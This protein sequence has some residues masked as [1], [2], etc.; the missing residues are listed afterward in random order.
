MVRDR[1]RLYPGGSIVA[2]IAAGCAAGFV[3]GTAG[4][5]VDRE[6]AGPLGHRLSTLI[7]SGALFTLLFGAGWTLVAATRLLRRPRH[8]TPGRIQHYTIGVS[9]VV[10]F[11]TLLIAVF[12][13][14]ASRDVTNRSP[15][16]ILIS[17][18]TLR[19]DHLSA[20]G[21]RRET[22][23]NLDALA[24]DGV[25]FERAFAQSP[26]TLPSHASMMTGLGPV[27]HG[28]VDLHSALTDA[29][30]TL[31]ERLG[32]MGYDTGAFVGGTRASFIGAKRRLDQ[33]FG[34][35][36]QYP[37]PRPGWSGLIARRLDHV[38]LKW[39]DH[40]VGNARAEIAASLRWIETR[41]RQPFFLF[42]HL[43]DVH[44]KTVR[45][46][47][48]AP[49]PFRERFCAGVDAAGFD[50]CA[51]GGHCASEYLHDLWSGAA[52]S[53]SPDTIERMK[54][55]YD[56]GIAFVDDE[57][58]R[59]FDRLRHLG[60][61]ENTLVVVTSDHGEAFFE[62][63]VPDHT[64]LYDEVLRVPLIL[65]GPGVPEGQRSPRYA[66][67]VDIAPT[68]L[69]LVG[70]TAQFGEGGSL[71]PLRAKRPEDSGGSEVSDLAL[72]KHR[73]DSV[74]LR[75]GQWKY[76]IHAPTEYPR[77]APRPHEELFDLA[78]DPEEQ[79][80]LVRTASDGRVEELREELTQIRRQAEKLNARLVEGSGKI[81]IH[82][83]ENELERLRVLGY[84]E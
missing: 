66:R 47:Y 31:A 70:D 53:P 84:A 63:R 19:A 50:G 77:V 69:A 15:S 43:F 62:H 36:A 13:F 76:V 48:E 30:E 33:G 28:A 56:G 22:S 75:R 78:S 54:C 14:P 29:H 71:F 12:G 20:Y 24:L 64:E 52:P 16:I 37:H 51:P 18:D 81:R 74:S 44:S 21:Y 61:W 68:I 65:H 10:M 79:I 60:L 45:L 58:G 46:P 34:F 67:T 6:V 1:S 72:N 23:A 25:L 83:D 80:N 5:L 41:A 49:E 17:I 8:L 82:L 7:L 4:L 59:F 32:R 38:R 9:A 35:Y 57:L 40:H 3:D 27:A 39:I 11:S 42:I 55:L 2:W 26:W 73:G